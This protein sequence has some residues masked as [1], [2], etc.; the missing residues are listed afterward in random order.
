MAKNI[1]M[2]L[3]CQEIDKHV[4]SNLTKDLW[5]QFAIAIKNI[6]KKLFSD[7]KQRGN[8]ANFQDYTPREMKRALPGLKN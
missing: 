7:K 3:I 2:P 6:P 5:K 1:Y 4:K 8:Q